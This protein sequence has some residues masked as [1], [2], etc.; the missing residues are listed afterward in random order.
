MSR[1]LLIVVLLLVSGFCNAQKRKPHPSQHNAPITSYKELGAKL[2]PINF[3]RRD[4]VSIRNEDITGRNLVIMLFNPTCDHCE[5]QAILFEQN[6]AAFLHTDLLLVAASGMGPYLGYFVN[7]IH[8]DNY[9][10]IQIALDSSDYI[11]QT[12]RYES[13]PQINIY[14]AKRKLIKV[15][16]GNAPI[17][18]I[19]RY[20]Q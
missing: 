12:F 7:N 5:K 4:G 17:D 8:A 6:M 3:Y 15:F 1:K 9:P 2:P 19:S 20:L 11:N 16:T 14:D 13:L 18:S 10:K